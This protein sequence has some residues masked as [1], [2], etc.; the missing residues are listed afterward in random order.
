MDGFQALLSIST[1]A[2][3]NWL[4]IL[5]AHSPV[6]LDRTT[7]DIKAWLQRSNR[8]FLSGAENTLM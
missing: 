5:A 6:F 4:A 1:R 2:P 7:M 3:A 8:F